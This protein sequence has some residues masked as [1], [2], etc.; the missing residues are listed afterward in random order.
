MS[1]LKSVITSPLKNVTDSQ[2]LEIIAMTEF[3]EYDTSIS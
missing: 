1:S 3:F 2:D